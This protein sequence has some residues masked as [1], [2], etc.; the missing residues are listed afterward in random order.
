MTELKSIL[1]VEDDPSIQAVARVALETVGGFEVTGCDDGQH[2]LETLAGFKPDLILMDVMMPNLDGPSTLKRL[3]A[4]PELSR[5]PVVFMTAK[6]QPAEVEEYRAIGA[7]D[8]LEKPFDPM[9]LADRL[10]RIWEDVHVD[11]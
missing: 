5:I 3:Q 1:H 6:I 10:K 2:A 11:P 4:D 8:V 7:A 9:T